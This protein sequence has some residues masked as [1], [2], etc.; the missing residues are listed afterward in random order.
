MVEGEGT[1]SLRAF[2][3][4]TESGSAKPEEVVRALGAL[5]GTSFVPL[6][7]VRESIAIAEPGTGGRVAIPSLVGADV[8]EGPAKPWGS[9]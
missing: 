7:T 3:R 9:C 8:P 2:V 5:A 6:R 4:L 1:P